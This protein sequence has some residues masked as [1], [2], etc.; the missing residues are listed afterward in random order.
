MFRMDF[1]KESS[2]S[3][4]L[5]RH[6]IWGVIAAAVM[7]LAG[8]FL[9][10]NPIAGSVGVGLLISIGVLFEGISLIGRFFGSKAK[11]GWDLALGI[12]N[13]VFA[14]WVLYIWRFRDDMWNAAFFVNFLAIYF[15]FILLAGGFEKIGFAAA[16][17]AAGSYHTGMITFS[18]FLDILLAGFLLFG[19]F[20]FRLTFLQV[21]GIFLVVTGVIHLIESIAM[22]F[23]ARPDKGQDESARADEPE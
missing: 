6:S 22:R 16:L 12:I 4:L 18:G 3:R 13:I 19:S 2:L 17:K 9:F 8:V 7:I 21:S 23:A 11:N 10:I 14:G 1:S 20:A 15:V 5:A